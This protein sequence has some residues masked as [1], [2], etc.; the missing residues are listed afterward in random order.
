[1][2]G[3]PETRRPQV[4]RAQSTV[5]SPLLLSFRGGGLGEPVKGGDSVA[6]GAP[7][8]SSLRAAAV[9]TCRRLGANPPP[10]KILSPFSPS[11]SEWGEPQPVII[12]AH[13]PLQTRLA[14]VCGR[15]GGKVT[16]EMEFILSQ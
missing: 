6:R 9:D 5:W 10:E 12:I 3:S 16:F 1:M 11:N 13:T 15:L 2:S 4:P 14:Q 8:R 7:Q